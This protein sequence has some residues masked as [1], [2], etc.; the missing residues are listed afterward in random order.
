MELLHVVPF[1]LRLLESARDLRLVEALGYLNGIQG[2]EDGRS[3]PDS[4]GSA[5][6]QEE[7]PVAVGALLEAA[8]QGNRAACLSMLARGVPDI[9]AIAT[10]RQRN[11]AVQEGDTVLHVAARR[12]WDDVCRLI[13][14]A[15][16]FNQHH[17]AR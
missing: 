5:N 3:E 1:P 9:N 4:A 10:S 14:A 16:R 17:Q 2:V 7:P 8:S 12:G 6:P 15:P 13:L 11:S